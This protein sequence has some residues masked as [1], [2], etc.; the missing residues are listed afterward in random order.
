[1]KKCNKCKV[2]KPLTEFHKN[3]SRKDGLQLKCKICGKIYDKR[4]NSENKEKI[5][6]Y[7]KKYYYNNQE[8]FYENVRIWDKENKEKKHQY[9]LDNIEKKRK[10][11]REWVIYNYHN[12]SQFKLKILLRSRISQSIK[13]KTNS[14]I[15][16]LGCDIETY[17][18]Y[19][20]SQFTKDMTW[21]N[22]GRVW[23]IDH[24]TPLNTFNLEDGNEQCQ[25]FN[26]K[27]TRP[28]SITE[29]RSRPKDGS[30]VV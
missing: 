15:D 5:N 13:D 12:N 28:L 2:E 3:K 7:N 24:I 27:N 4:Y 19:L 25:A 29:N 14:S 21:E 6:L 22:H 11:N 20:E 26:Y 18:N 9:Y 8:Y 23:E 10:Q 30:D 16:L 1:M 17:Y